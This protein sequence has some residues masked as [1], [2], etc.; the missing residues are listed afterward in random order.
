[1]RVS[2]FACLVIAGVV[3]GPELA[4]ADSRLDRALA[5]Q[6]CAARD[7]KCDWL[8]TLSSLERASVARALTA[9]GYQVDPLPWGKVIGAVRVYNEDVFAEGSR[10]LRFFNYFHVTTKE[11]AV[12]Q[13]VVIAA[14]EIWDQ[15]RVEETARRLRD[16]LWS[17]VVA[18]IP[19][20]ASDPAK[21]DLLVVTRDIWS[22]RLNTQYQVQQRSLTDL[23]IALSENNF[24]G[25]RS[26]LAAAFTMNQATIATGPLFIDK[27]LFGQHLDF[28]ARVDAI[29]NR[30][31][32]FDDSDLVREGSQSSIS[33]SRSLWSLASEWGAGASFAH[34][35]AITRSFRGLELRT[36]DIPETEEVEALPHI[37][38]SKSWSTNVYGVRQWGS[39]W[40]SQ[41]TIGH[42][43]DSQHP[44]LV[45][46][47]PGTSDQREPFIR[48]VLPRDEVTSVPYISYGLF[49][50]RFKKLR[51]VGTF[52]LA[53]DSRL[54]LDF[55]VSYGVGLKFLGSDAY[56]QRGGASVG[57]GFPLGDDGLIRPAVS[58]N[59]RY[60]GGEIIDNTASGA[61]RLITPT[62]GFARIVALGSVQ[63]RWN[64]TQ[65]R[66]FAIGSDSGLRGFIID[67]FFGDR[68][69]R[70]QVEVRTTPF[71]VWVLRAGGV[72]FYDVGSS[73]D[74][75]REMQLHHDVGLGFRMLVPQT[76]RELFRFDLAFP[77]DGT[78]DTKQLRPRFIAGF[79]SAF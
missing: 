21:V 32:L 42:S 39:R 66:F 65:N 63:T 70:G 31:A 13:E 74:T 15:E 9:R 79:E 12:A 62:V 57:Y 45:S 43:V 28:R 10:V 33:I 26:V 55:D 77:L 58:F 22:L 64:D 3:A 75:F 41:L 47:F 48:D 72:L 20:V 27:N 59:V 1:M 76:S 30:D 46:S 68:L 23:S 49:E 4:R 69:V 2:W 38:R 25:T 53:E 61:L 11:R 54:G 37:Y 17:S 56:F 8:A 50:P 44:S 51:N 52:E 36:Y 67:E 29:L 73:A 40:K 5:E 16:P 19:V 18:V 78:A 35:F 71:P 24:L 34:R 60:Q 7:P 14:G 6:T